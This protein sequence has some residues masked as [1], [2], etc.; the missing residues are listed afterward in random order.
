[1]DAHHGHD[2]AA[3]HPFGALLRIDDPPVGAPGG[4][5]TV[6][7]LTAAKAKAARI[8]AIAENA[9]DLSIR[10]GYKALAADLTKSATRA[11]LEPVFAERSQHLDRIKA[12]L[13]TFCH[14][15]GILGYPRP[16]TF[17]GKS[18]PNPEADALDRKAEAW[19]PIDRDASAGYRQKA[20]ELRQSGA[21]TTPRRR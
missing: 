5:R 9:P 2:H 18:A 16:E 10:A 19:A 21:A 12:E 1:L 20:A 13:D 6:T 4:R 15:Q 11:A 7:E 14:Q 8:A 3:S 17:I